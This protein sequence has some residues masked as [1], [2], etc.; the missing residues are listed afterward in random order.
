MPL[1][2][3]Q[4]HA[5]VL[6]TLG[7]TKTQV[8]QRCSVARSTLDHWLTDREFYGV[9]DAKL[10]AHLNANGEKYLTLAREA[11]TGM[12]E[13][14]RLLCQAV[15]DENPP[16]RLRLMAATALM[17]EGRKWLDRLGFD[18]KAWNSAVEIAEEERAA[19]PSAAAAPSAVPPEK[20]EPPHANGTDAAKND[21][22]RAPVSV[23]TP[24]QVA[25]A[26][27]SGRN[28]KAAAPV[29]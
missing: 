1:N 3:K 28:E 16:D 2:A 10:Q 9:Y 11:L 21:C 15:T 4:Q 5:I 18:D 20:P 8:A 25:Q 29:T 7:V 24:S 19:Q 12:V 6:L 17:R 23:T 22:A 26:Q 13:A 14:Q 27:S